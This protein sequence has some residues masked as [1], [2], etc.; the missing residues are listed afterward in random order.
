MANSS[1]LAVHRRGEA[2]GCTAIKPGEVSASA[3]NTGA[4]G[5]TSAACSACS[6]TYEVWERHWSNER[7]TFL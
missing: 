6:A 5:T 3:V 1:V 7:V 4:V 2:V